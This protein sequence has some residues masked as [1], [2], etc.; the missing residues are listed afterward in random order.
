MKLSHIALAAAAL[1]AA[2]PS[3]AG[4]E[5]L[6]GAS[7]STVNV[8]R[9][10]R[11]LC[12]GNGGAF[13]LRKQSSSTSSLGNIFTASCT[14][15]VF[16]GTTDEVR[17]NVGGGSLGAVNNSTPGGGI[18]VPMLA[19]SLATCSAL[20]AGSGPLS[21]IPAGEML[22]CGTATGTTPETANGGY[23]DVDGT[24]FRA[25]NEPIPAGVN[26]ATDYLAAPFAQVF[27][28]AVSADLYNALQAYQVAKGQLDA[29]CA[30]VAG[31]VY[32]ATGFT[33]PLCQPSVSRA[34]IASLINSTSTNLYKQAGANAFLGGTTTTKNDLT[35]GKT[36][37]PDVPLKSK[38]T[39]CR[40]PS[41][42]GTQ[43]AA[44]LYFLNS[45]TGTGDVGGQIG[46]FGSKTAP[47][48]VNVGTT[49]TASTNSGSSDVKT[50][51]NATGYAVGP[52]S[53]ENNPIGGSDLFRF[54]K[55]SNVSM[56]GGVAGDSQTAEAI[57]GNYDYV[58]TSAVY[59]PGGTCTP[60]I[61]ALENSVP[62]GSSSPGIF[63]K[64]ESNFSRATATRPYV[65][66]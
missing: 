19:P 29:S 59:C 36:L 35:G 55:L 23:M 13:I 33:T 30:T 18:A 20:A 14:G 16:T 11:N 43:A 53:A 1:G 12:T 62:V 32:T 4:I 15:A 49:Y 6:A 51:L 17:V 54:V 66:K 28:I 60:I 34:Q 48:T 7:A 39:N 45:P 52:L 64:S 40:R 63:L 26:D 24:I 8:V 47:A 21:F 37:S 3:F 61:T 5:R 56:T 65:S 31:N 41:T 2:T 44:Q 57:A 9:G 10:L 50:C 46:A 25:N 58:F 22:N 38:I 42:S 27:G